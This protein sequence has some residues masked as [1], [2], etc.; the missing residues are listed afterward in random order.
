MTP[1]PVR[2]I[3]AL[4]WLAAGATG[5][6]PEEETA[7]PAPSEAVAA[8]EPVLDQI[9]VAYEG[10]TQ[11]ESVRMLFD[12]A[13]GKPLGPRM[14]WFGPGQSSYSWAWLAERHHVPQEDA[15]ARAAFAGTAEQ[16]RS[17]DRDSDER[18][19]SD[20]LNWSAAAK[21]PAPAPASPYEAIFAEEASRPDLPPKDE[22]LRLFFAGELGSL[23][24]GPSLGEPAPD[25]TLEAADHS[26]AVRLYDLLGEKPVVLA[27]GSLTCDPFRGFFADV[28]AIHERFKDDARFLFI[29]VREAHP[30]DGWAKDV[31]Y[32]QGIAV[33]QPKVFAQRVEAARQCRNVLHP[34]MPVLVDGIGDATAHAYSALPAR[35]YV[36]DRDGLI[37]YKGGRGPVSLSPRELEQALALTLLGQV[38]GAPAGQDQ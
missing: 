10:E 33:A 14:G 16:F 3:C 27:F 1:K 11:P 9:K 36:L 20:D 7:E 8:P 2:T 35:F 18:L 38:G 25:F 26:G 15:I 19:T 31:N 32:M 30:S 22:L 4:T 23:N 17:L 29:Y 6:R 5:C 12:L 13:E 34:S 37:T 21:Q 24:Q 28:E